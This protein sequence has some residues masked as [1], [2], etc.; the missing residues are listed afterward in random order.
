[1]GREFADKIIESTG[2]NI[3]HRGYRAFYTHPIGEWPNHRYGDYIT[4]P[5]K[6]SFVDQDYYYQLLF[7]ELAHYCECRVGHLGDPETNEVVAEIVSF[8][9][10]SA[11]GI[12]FTWDSKTNRR[13]EGKPGKSIVSAACKVAK[14]ILSKVETEVTI[15]AQ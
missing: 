8:L 1:V 14:F 2:A 6:E 4:M 13:L 12:P 5:P 9:L 3:R 15:P 10:C 11:A 7:H